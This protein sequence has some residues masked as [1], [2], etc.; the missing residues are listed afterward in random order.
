MPNTEDFSPSMLL[1]LA[2]AAALVI[3]LALKFWL[4]SRQIRHVAGHRASVPAAFAERIPLTAHQKAADYT[5]TKARLG[6]LEMALGAAVLLGWTLL[7][8]LDALNQALLA[9]L[10]GGMWQQLALLAAFA[11]ISGLIDLP[12]S[13]YQ[14]FVVEERFGFNKMT[15][16]LWLADALKG[17]LVGAIIGL[18]IAALILWLMGAAGPMWWLWAWGFWMG[19]NLLLMVVY[20]TFIAPLFNKFQP[21]EDESLKARV[22]ALMQRCGFSAKGLF[23]MDGSRRSAHANAYFTGFG[24]A[25]RVVF[26]DTLLRQLAPG[27]VEAVLAHELGHFKHRHIIQRIVGLFAMSLAGFALLGWLSNQVWF[28]T[29][30]GVRPSISL[31]AG[32]ASAPNDALALLLFMLAVP[33]FTFFISPLFARQSRRHEFQA[34]AYAVAQASGA[35]LSS[36]LLKLYEDNASTLT[37]D[38]LYVSFYYSHPPATERLA[39]MHTPTLTP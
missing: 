34:D 8:G 10:G 3:G 39:R 1:T 25:K 24:A 32:V 20:P 11:A 33:V 14:T 12:L 6:L 27:E 35:D 9:V 17:L 29:G 21:L 16:R 13:L 7:G 38:P 23:V 15:L 36:A 2:F 5:I 37:P 22:T 18:P 31:D 4:A 28:Y 30:L 19:F 26:Y